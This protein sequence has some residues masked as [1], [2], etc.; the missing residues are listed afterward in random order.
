MSDGIA[1]AHASSSL[2]LLT[3][4][5]KCLARGHYVVQIPKRHIGMADEANARGKH[6]CQIRLRDRLARLIGKSRS[7]FSPKIERKFNELI[8]DLAI[9]G[10]LKGAPRPQ[11]EP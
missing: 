9:V 8:N 11:Q 2:V 3:E 1:I 4:I 6:V 7:R 5:R 10:G